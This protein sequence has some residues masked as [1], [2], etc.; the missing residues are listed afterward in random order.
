MEHPNRP[1][2]GVT[3]YEAS[4][5]AAWARGRLLTSAEWVWAARGNLGREY[6]W[7][8]E[9]PDATRANYGATGPKE[10]TP[11]GL[12]PCG[13]TPEGVEDMA[14]NVWEWTES[15]YDEEHTRKELRGGS[16]GDNPSLLRAV[17]ID[18]EPV[19]RRYHYIGFRVAREVS[20]T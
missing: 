19:S 5:Y 3:W 4:A 13:A 6:P 12:Y 11:V 2:T 7:G 18:G 14:G 1:V 10:Q 15:W 20:V 9:E 17:S 8:N 16:L